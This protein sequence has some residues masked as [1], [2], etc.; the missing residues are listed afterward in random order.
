MERKKIDSDYASAMVNALTGT[1]TESD[2]RTA[3]K[4]TYGPIMDQVQAGALYSSTWMGRKIVDIPAEDMVKHWREFDIA[5][6]DPSVIKTIRDVEKKLHIKSRVLTAIKWARLFG[7]SLLIMG[8]RDGLPLDQPLE[9]NSVGEGDLD[10]VQVLDM[11]RVGAQGMNTWNP[12]SEDFLEPLHYNIF[13]SL[14]HHSRVIKFIGLQPT[15]ETISTYNYFGMS[16]L[17][18]MYETIRDA[19][20]GLAGASNM[21]MKASQDV[22]KTPQLWDF[23]GTNEESKISQRFALMQK[24][25]SMLN[26]LVLDKDESFESVS[27][28]FSGLDNVLTALLDQVVGASGIPRTKFFGDSPR[29]MNAT[30]ESDMRNY[31]DEIRNGQENILRPKLE[32]LD[33]VFIR[34]AIGDMPESYSFTFNN[35]F[36]STPQEQAEIDDKN[37]DKLKKLWDVG[38]PIDVLLRDAIEMKLS[39]NLTEESLVEILEDNEPE[40]DAYS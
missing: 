14:V 25:R 1:G 6:S 10:F 11:H 15:Y 32:A 3:G 33:E 34:S 12:F 35:L 40:P 9:L 8:V 30:G 37:L 20:Q 31:Y 22:L 23:V 39:K 38:V 18:P 36:Q 28:T 24:Q 27:T 21:T 29:G 16:V 2:S 5:D 13:G 7:G 26:L 17:Q 4:F 19:M